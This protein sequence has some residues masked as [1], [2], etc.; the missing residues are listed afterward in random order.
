MRFQIKSEPKKSPEPIKAVMWRIEDED[1]REAFGKAL[2]DFGGSATK[3]VTQMVQHCLAEAGYT[4]KH[5]KRAC[6]HSSS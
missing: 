6:A 4:V 1:L 3:L 2:A 5:S